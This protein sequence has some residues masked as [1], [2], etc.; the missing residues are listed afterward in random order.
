MDTGKKPVKRNRDEDSS[1]HERKVKSRAETKDS[2]SG[3]LYT[4]SFIDEKEEAELLAEI[5]RQPWM[6]S[7]RRRVQHYGWVYD[8]K[9]RQVT[10]DNY[11]GPLPAWLRNLAQRLITSGITEA[12]FDQVIVNEYIPGQGI[13]K[14][15]DQPQM[16][17]DDIVTISLGSVVPMEFARRGYE[18][19]TQ[20][21]QP[22]SA[23]RFR[24]EAR[25]RYTHCI[26]ARKSDVNPIT[27]QVVPRGRR[28]SLTFRTVK[29]K[30]VS[31]RK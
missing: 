18:K 21:L 30:N 10:P 25:Y 13:G 11:I 16:F 1:G 3:L 27:G 20:Y 29:Q 15:I 9:N 4:E 7:L 19:V 26:P 12:V 23:L 5:D 17:G 28:V 22:R 24:G 31:G 6:N 2:I 8:Y 14:H